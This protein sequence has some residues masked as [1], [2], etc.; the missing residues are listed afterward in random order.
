RN[1]NTTVCD[2]SSPVLPA[3]PPSFE[4][5]RGEPKFEYI[6]NEKGE[7]LKATTYLIYFDS[8]Q[9]ETPAYMVGHF[10]N[11]LLGTQYSLRGYWKSRTEKQT[12][13]YVP[14]GGSSQTISTTYHESLYHR[15]PTRQ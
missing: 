7:F 9:I 1:L 5:K 3:P 10:A 15:Q 4:Y 11:H 14:G 12:I 13:D 2:P 6:F 8:T